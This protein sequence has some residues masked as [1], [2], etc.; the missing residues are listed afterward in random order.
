MIIC[1][2]FIWGFSGLGFMVQGL[3]LKKFRVQG[4]GSRGF[5]GDPVEET[6]AGCNC[7]WGRVWPKGSPLGPNGP[8]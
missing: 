5:G 3:G 4:L 8:H 7:Q 1:E 2:A 6:P